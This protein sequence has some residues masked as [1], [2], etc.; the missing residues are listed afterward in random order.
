MIH[1]FL[2]RN[3]FSCERRFVDFESI[4]FFE[5]TIRWN[6]VAFCENNIVSWDK[7]LHGNS[8]LSPIT[9][10]SDFRMNHF[11]ECLE[12]LFRAI[13]LKKTDSAIEK[14]NY[15]D[16]DSISNFAIYERYYCCTY[17]NQYENIAKLSDKDF[18]PR[19]FIGNG[20]LI[21]SVLFESFCCFLR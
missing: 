9:Y 18:V 8:E 3:T 15:E 4:G 17:K 7:I 5:D 11:F 10:G 13:F 20:E 19:I 16:Y 14:N 6:F 12:R 2:D 1:L 21:G